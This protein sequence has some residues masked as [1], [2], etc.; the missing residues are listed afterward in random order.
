MREITYA[1][2]LREALREEMKRDESVILIGEDIGIHG[3]AFSVTKGLIE[4]FGPERVRNT[5]ISEAGFVGAA[6][7]AALTGLRPIA[8]IMYIDF[9]TIAMDQIVN[10]AAKLRFMT[11]GKTCVPLVLR[12]QGGAGRGNAAQHSQSLE[13]WY[14]HIPG[15]LVVMPSSPYDAKGLLKSSIRDNNPI[16]FIEHKLLYATKGEVPDEGQEYLVPIGKADIKRKGSDVT[17]VTWS[18]MVRKALSAAEMLAEDGIAAEVVD[19][20]TLRP[21][22]TE[23]IVESVKRTGRCIV[24]HEACK[25]GGFGAEVVARVVEEA[26]DYLDAPVLRVAAADTPIPYSKTLEDW[27]IP[28]EADIVSAVRRVVDG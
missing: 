12:T 3:G 6:I 19:V 7:G 22:D 20:R 11:G 21:L 25:T 17:I 1:Q 13:A 16:I 23:T 26:F 10:Q 14:A 15:L 18:L 4:E 27:V 9:S 8:E 28:S 24:V 5:P 2:A